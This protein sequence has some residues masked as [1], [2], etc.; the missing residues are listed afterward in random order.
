MSQGT[1][2]IQQGLNSLGYRTLSGAM[3][4]ED[5]IFGENTAA[6][7]REWLDAN[8][9]PKAKPPQ[10]TMPLG[11]WP[12]QANVSKYFGAAGGPDA[13]AG[14]CQLPFAFPLAWDASQR[15]TTF[16]CH[17]LV[18]LP[19]TRI[20]AAAAAHYGEAEYRRLRLDQFGGCYN[21]R[22]MRGGSSISMHAYGIAV[23]LDP[24]NNGLNTRAPHAT[25]SRIDY[26]PFWKIVEG[27]GA[28]SLGR[29]RN[30]DWMHF[31]FATL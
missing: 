13:T 19:L 23:D 29:E 16:S 1:K 24:I 27:E 3:L 4:K 22:Q 26:E 11:K 28:V 14:R 18:A 5:G 25:F 17:R 8:G 9:E 10:A 2:L 20:F 6:A 7:A 12:S 30:F 31:Q 15:V 21:Y